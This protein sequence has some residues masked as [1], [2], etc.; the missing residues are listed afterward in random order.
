[1]LRREFNRSL[2]RKDEQI[3]IHLRLQLFDRQFRLELDQRLWQSYLDL[4]LQQESIWPRSLYE[5]AKTNQSELIENYIMTQ[6]AMID[7]QIEQ[8]IMELSRQAQSESPI[9]ILLPSL[10]IMDI[11]LKKYVRVQQHHLLKRMDDQLNRCKNDIR[12]QHLHRQLFTYPLLTNSQRTTLEQLIHQRKVHL[13]VYEEFIMFEQRI[14]HQ[15]LPVNFD[16]LEKKH[17]S[18]FLLAMHR[19][20]VQTSE[21]GNFG[22]FGNFNYRVH[23]SFGNFCNFLFRKSEHTSCIV[24]RTLVDVRIQRRNIIKRGK[25]SLLN[26]YYVAYEYKMNDCE[27]QYQ[28]LF[29]EFEIG[30]TAG[31]VTSEID[32]L[33]FIDAIKAYIIHY[34]KRILYDIYQKIKHFREILNQRYQRSS[35][36]KKMVG[37]SPE[38]TIELLSNPFKPEELEYLSLGESYIRPN[39][40]ILRPEKHRESQL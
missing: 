33:S 15:F 38:V 18:K 2:N 19:S 32:G 36:A 28:Q 39:Q 12:D 1:M 14:L 35:S 10:E 3:F 20:S 22:S 4:G 21:K 24:D 11:E 37:A 26:L 7:D 31:T 9:P 25:R 27:Q 16:E 34:T 17:C 29:N 23:G 8:C 13:D 6:L 30:F 5:M 40:S